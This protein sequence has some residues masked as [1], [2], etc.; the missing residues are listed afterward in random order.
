[1]SRQ[2]VTAG[3]VPTGCRV[4]TV[5]AV[6]DPVPSSDPGPGRSGGPPRQ[7]APASWGTHPPLQPAPLSPYGPVGGVPGPHWGPPCPAPQ[8]AFAGSWQLGAPQ[9]STVRARKGI[10]VLTGLLMMAGLACA[11]VATGV[12]VVL[13]GVGVS[14]PVGD[15][16][17]LG[18]VPAAPE[19]GRVS[20]RAPVPVT[21]L[22]ALARSGPPSLPRPEHVGG[23]LT[24][25]VPEEGGP[26]T[27]VRLEVRVAGSW[28]VEDVTS[29]DAAGAYVLRAP[30]WFGRHTARVVAPPAAGL[31]ADAWRAT[32]G[33]EVTVSPDY[34]P[35]GSA[36]SY[37]VFSSDAR[38]D[39]C[40][41]IVWKYN[42]S[43]GYPGAFDDASRALEL[44]GEGSGLRFEYGG[45][46]DEMPFAAPELDQRVE[47]AAAHLLIGWSTPEVV[48]ELGGNVL[49][50]GGVLEVGDHAG[51]LVEYT[52]G[53]LVLDSTE[54]S[55]VPA[56]FHEGGVVDWGAVMLHELGH[57]VGLD[58]VD[59][60]SQLM[61]GLASHGLRL[62]AGDLA[63][64]RALG[65][66]AG[67][68]SPSWR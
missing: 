32:P 35:A 55:S 20:S 65:A 34:E 28:V 58:H 50:Y 21:E 42:G 5:S 39:P 51:G 52:A 3:W 24:G 8:D 33:F 14:A 38:W 2:R 17:E 36:R 25:V 41:P 23:R 44:I 43:G 61:H 67:C 56:G 4:G 60:S 37:E 18:L 45:P 47:D 19:A 12:V 9:P 63:G 53:A 1:M 26:R 6:T 64:L 29:T 13:S 68:I 54:R 57:V 27:R 59:D 11:L 40:E 15:E 48:P 16:A 62:G 66:E 22:E 7:G 10:S 46:T 49:G 30:G 31:S